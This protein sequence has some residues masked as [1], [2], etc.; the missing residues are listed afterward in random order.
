ML[1]N[2]ESRNIY[3]PQNKT[4]FQL[5]FAFVKNFVKKMYVGLALL[6]STS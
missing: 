1:V 5:N 3:A 6:P 2:I 4:Q